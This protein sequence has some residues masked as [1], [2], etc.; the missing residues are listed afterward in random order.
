MGAIK[1]G[2]CAH[3]RLACPHA[4]LHDQALLVDV[5]FKLGT[6]HRKSGRRYDGQARRVEKWNQGG[7]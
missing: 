6:R 2:A 3:F 4:L 7:S 5:L 1:F